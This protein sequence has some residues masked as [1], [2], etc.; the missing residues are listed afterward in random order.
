MSDE[1]PAGNCFANVEGSGHDPQYDNPYSPAGKNWKLSWI[2]LIRRAFKG[3]NYS[4]TSCCANQTV[5]KSADNTSFTISC[6]SSMHGAHVLMG[7]T[8]SKDPLKTKDAVFLLPLCSNH[9]T[10][11]EI[12]RHYGT[13]YYMKLNRKMKAVK[14]RG[15]M[16]EP[17]SGTL[18]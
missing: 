15:Y 8:E 4:C 6:S 14:L 10:Y 3:T 7:S 9:N 17:E 16:K 1:Y 18:L 2:E 5:Y 12:T 13:G 11:S